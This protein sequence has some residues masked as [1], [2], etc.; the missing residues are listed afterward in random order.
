MMRAVKN[1]KT[2]KSAA[3]QIPQRSARRDVAVLDM[4]VRSS[5][6]MLRTHAN[7]IQVMQESQELVQSA[8]WTFVVHF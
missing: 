2:V 1:T 7:K 8:T 3:E 4:S 5:G 6:R